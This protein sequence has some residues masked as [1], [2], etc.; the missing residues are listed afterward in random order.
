MAATAEKAFL[1]VYFS[2]LIEFV[3]MFEKQ[4]HSKT[5]YHLEC[6]ANAL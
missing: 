3:S 4:L 5:V 2:G 6:S 1:F